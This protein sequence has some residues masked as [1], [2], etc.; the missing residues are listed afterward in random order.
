MRAFVWVAFLTLALLAPLDLRPRRAPND[1]RPNVVVILTDDQT[2]ESL[3]HQPSPMPW[4]TG[5]LADPNDHWVEFANAFVNTPVCCPSRATLLTGRYSHHT[6]VR[7]NATGH[8]LDESQ[9][10]ATWLHD[11]GYWTGLFGKYMNEYPFGRGPYVPPGWDRWSG[12]QQGSVLSIYYGYTLIQQGNPRTYGTAPEDYS[13]DVLAGQA[14]AFIR[15]APPDRPFYLE[16]TPTAPHG[17]RTPPPRYAHAFDATPVPH[18]PSFFEPDV[19]DK[20]AWVRALPGLT[21]RRRAIVDDMQQ[22]QYSTLLAVDDAVRAIVAELTQRG[23]LDDT[24]ILLTSDNGFAMGAH[25]WIAKSCPYEECVHV[26]FLVRF[27]GAEARTD[28]RPVSNVDIAVT[29]ADLAG[30]PTGLAPDGRSLVPLLRNVKPCRWR[31]GVLLEWAGAMGVPPWWEVRTP[32]YAYTE[33]VTGEVELYDLTGASGPGDPFE[34]ENRAADPA[35]ASVRAALA[36]LLEDLRSGTV[37]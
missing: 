4:L 31:K 32:D 20:P 24:V 8:L 6:G 19:S 25:R 30:V 35:Y 36:A 28:D 7:D 1:E 12:K 3:H 23:E 26:P 2:L 29:V 13:T 21:D 27:P 14:L 5:R 15:E 10:L 11:A 16:L 9:T 22:R 17:P 33:Y 18:P 37:H 34:L